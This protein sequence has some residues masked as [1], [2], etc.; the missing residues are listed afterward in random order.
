MVIRKC[1]GALKPS[2]R[3]QGCSAAPRPIGADRLL[4]SRCEW[5]EPDS[6]A[7]RQRPWEATTRRSASLALWATRLTQI[8]DC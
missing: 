8:D 3:L 1:G 4:G 5:R 2:D 6:N 7:T